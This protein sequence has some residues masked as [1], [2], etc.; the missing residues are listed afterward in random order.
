MKKIRLVILT[1]C[2]SLLT[3][4]IAL[5]NL[6]DGLIGHYSFDE[7][8]TAISLEGNAALSPD[9]GVS[10]GALSLDGAG[11]Y[12][13]LG[14]ESNFE[15]NT[16]FSLSLWIKRSNLGKGILISKREKSKTN[17]GWV[18]RF[19]NN[20]KLVFVLCTQKRYEKIKVRTR[21]SFDNTSS[22]YYVLATS[23]GSGTINGLEIYVDG[24]PQ[25]T[26]PWKGQTHI[27]NA[28]HR[29]QHFQLSLSC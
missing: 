10:N 19:N 17:R 24:K 2:I 21:N 27:H 11:S 5:S 26:R 29:I 6:T 28:S 1:L 9:A 18:L 13:D 25:T 7:D 12:A 8:N 16:P 23:D 20:N 14:D 15:Y 4:G 22:Y 3:A